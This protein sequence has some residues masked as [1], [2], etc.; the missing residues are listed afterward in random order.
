MPMLREKRPKL[1][2]HLV[3]GPLPFESASFDVVFSKDAIVHIPDK[4]AL[5]RSPHSE[6]PAHLKISSA[7]IMK[8]PVERSIGAAE[9]LAAE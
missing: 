3:P 6:P 2:R 9:S 7:T 8:V 1:L 4:A 5:K